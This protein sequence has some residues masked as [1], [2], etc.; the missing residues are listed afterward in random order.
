MQLIRYVVLQAKCSSLL[1]DRNQTDIIC[2]ASRILRRTR[3][4][5]NPSNRSQDRAEEC[6]LQQGKFPQLLTNLNQLCSLYAMYNACVVD[7]WCMIRY[8]VFNFRNI[9]RNIFSLDFSRKYQCRFNCSDTDRKTAVVVITTRYGLEGPGSNPGRCKIFRNRPDR[10]EYHQVIPGVIE[11][12]T[13]RW[14]H[15]LVPSLKKQWSCTSTSRSEPSSPVLGSIL[16]FILT[17]NEVSK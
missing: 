5:K 9:R 1:T 4:Q 2:R 6:C 15:P 16:P 3:F 11:V 10:P 17:E 7:I 14:P 12:G 13:W 8:Y